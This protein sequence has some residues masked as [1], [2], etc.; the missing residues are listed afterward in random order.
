MNLGVKMAKNKITILKNGIDVFGKK[1]EIL[2]NGEII[3]KI[4]QYQ[5]CTECLTHRPGKDCR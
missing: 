1:I 4:W 3:E 5:S 2:I